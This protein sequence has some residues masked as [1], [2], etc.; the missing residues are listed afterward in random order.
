[1]N[2]FVNCCDNELPGN[3]VPLACGLTEEDYLIIKRVD[4]YLAAGV[5]LKNWW[6]Q[7]H[8]AGSF[9]QQFELQRV[10][11]RPGRSFGFFDEVAYDGGTLPVMGNFQEMF[12]DQPRTPTRL[13]QEAAQ[14]M[15]S[16]I[17]EFALRYFMRVSS[18][19]QPGIYVEAQQPPGF[20]CPEGLS[21]CPEQDVLR[22]GFGFSQLYFK[23]QDT[24]EVGKFQDEFA[25][26]DLRELEWK[27]EWIVVKVRIF[28][29]R[30]AFSP[31]GGDGPELVVPL[32]EESY[33]VLSRDFIQNIDEPSSGVIGQYGLGY[34]FIKDPVQSLVAYGPGQFDAAIELINFEVLETGVINVSMSFVVNRPER[35]MSVSLDPF[36]WSFRAADFFSF[37]LTSRLLAP[38]KDALQNFTMPV[39]T[40][41][42]PITS[43]ISLANL[44]TANRAAQEFCISREQLEKGLLAQ[45]FIQ[46]YATIVGSLLTWRQIPDWLDSA[47]L[48]AWVVNGRSS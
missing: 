27:Y 25:I 42:D 31:F 1:M 7:T 48:P 45:H 37:G 30:F 13:Q 21:W 17:R 29:F 35:I 41:F 8:R 16:Q 40:G 20:R 33:L 44:L 10:F 22:E 3:G 23:L 39:A 15:R 38:V 47:A 14:W 2:T 11:N 36:N 34:A 28:D 19:R 12:Y 18:F 46:H 24:G 5:S 32:A 43:Y 4:Q 9:Q 6:D 26:I